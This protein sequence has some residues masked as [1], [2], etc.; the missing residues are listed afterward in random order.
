MS[1]G[2]QVCNSK[3]LLSFGSRLIWRERAPGTARV[4]VRG[5]ARAA[6][7]GPKCL[8]AGQ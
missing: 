7:I 6:L 5:S 3:C 4:C 2:T 8:S 1:E